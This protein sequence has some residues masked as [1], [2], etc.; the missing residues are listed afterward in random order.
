MNKKVLIIFFI[1][2]LFTSI[3]LIIAITIIIIKKIS[4][5]VFVFI[6]NGIKVL[7]NIWGKH[8]YKD[9]I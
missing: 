6:F 5:F 9:C 3:L 1:I 8:K 2:I 7:K 4:N